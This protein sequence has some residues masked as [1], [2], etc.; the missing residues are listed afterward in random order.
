M[1]FAGITAVHVP[2]RGAAP[3]MQALLTGGAD[4]F[5][6][7]LTQ[8]LPLIAAD[9]VV[10]IATSNSKRAT[11]LPDVPTFKEMGFKDFTILVQYY[12]MAPKGVP[13]TVINKIRT[14]FKAVMDDAEIRQRFASI[15]FYPKWI[16]GTAGTEQIRQDL[17]QWAAVIKAANIKAEYTG[18]K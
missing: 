15:A 5:C 16:E 11:L 8:A 2:Y 6:G 12:L 3:A 17:A 14:D 13:S 18:S 1:Q 4:M 10:P 7:P 9:Q